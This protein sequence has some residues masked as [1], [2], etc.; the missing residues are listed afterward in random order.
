MQAWLCETLDGAEAL[1]WRDLPTP[2]PAAGEVR[3]AVKA[4][5]LNFPRSPDRAEQVPDQA[6]SALRARRGIRR[7]GRRGGRRRHRNA[8]GHDRV[9]AL[10][11]TGGFGTHA[12][13]PAERVL[14]VPRASTSSTPPPS[15]LHL[16]HLAPRAHGPRRSC[17]PAR[18]CWCWAPPAAWARP[19]VQI[20]K[21]AGARV[22]AAASTDEKCALCARVGRRCHHQLHAPRT[23]A[24]PQEADRR[25]GPRRGLRPGGRRSGRAGVPLGRLARPLPGH[26]LC[27]RRHSGGAA[28]PASAQG[29][30]DRGGVLGRVRATRTRPTPPCWQQWRSGMPKAR[31][32][33]SSTSALPMSEL[34][35]AY[36]RMGNNA[37]S[38]GQGG[39]G[40][41]KHW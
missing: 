17:R 39:A 23:S 14:P 8:R 11:G 20:A 9:A 22:I 3:I 30:V 37:R 29:R 1:H 35:A 40:Q 31:S 33:R 16:R 24:T 18:P 26:R 6:P 32:S 27:R 34:H 5:S 15:C 28:E 10:G 2:E 4:A 13:V 21:A 38:A 12:I 19:R 41:R 7:R 25:Q 36:A